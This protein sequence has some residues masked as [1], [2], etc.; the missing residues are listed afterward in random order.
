[1]LEQFYDSE[2]RHDVYVDRH[3]LMKLKGIHNLSI[4]SLQLVVLRL[5]FID[6]IVEG[7]GALGGFCLQSFDLL[8]L[9]KDYGVKA[10]LVAIHGLENRKI[11]TMAFAVAFLNGV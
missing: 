4:P 10:G 9:T 7:L 11:S 1:M 3:V 6:F 8:L 2:L 5:R